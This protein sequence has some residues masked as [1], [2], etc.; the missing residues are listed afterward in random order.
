MN[1]GEWVLSK[2]DTEKVYD[3]FLRRYRRF[4]DDAGTGMREHDIVE[5]WEEFLGERHGVELVKK[6]SRLAESVDYLL[7]R[8]N[9]PGWNNIVIRDPGNNNH[10]LI[11]ERDLAEKVLVL[12][13]VP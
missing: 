1:I 3:I 2:S 8:V 13:E 9:Q 4:W 7:D 5:L 11:L 12:G 6:F 10:F